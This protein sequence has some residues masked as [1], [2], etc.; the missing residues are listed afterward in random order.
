[1]FG[2]GGLWVLRLCRVLVFF[3]VLVLS[4]LLRKMTE[5]SLV[6]LVL[7]EVHSEFY[8]HPVHTVQRFV[9]WVWGQA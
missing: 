6:S 4:F 5:P 7:L 1:M 9:L 2:G 8:G 3:T